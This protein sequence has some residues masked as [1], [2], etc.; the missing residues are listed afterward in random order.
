MLDDDNQLCYWFT[1]LLYYTFYII[2]KGI[3]FIYEYNFLEKSV[4]CYVSSSFTR[5]MF[6]CLLIASF[7]AVLSL[8]DLVL[9]CTVA[10]IQVC[11]LGARD[12]TI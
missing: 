5:L 3:P 8:R 6:T 10:A 7:P 11:S 4:L 9:F 12:Y 1:Y 2:L